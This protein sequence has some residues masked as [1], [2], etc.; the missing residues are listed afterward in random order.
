MRPLARNRNAARAG[1]GH[2]ALARWICDIAYILASMSRRAYRVLP[3]DTTTF[4]ARLFG[5]H[6]AVAS[7][8][9]LSALAGADMLKAGGN[10]IDAAVAASFVEGLVN[11]Q[12]HTIGG[13]CPLLLRLAG[14][15]ER[16]YAIN[17]NGAA[18]APDWTEG[19]LSAAELHPDGRLEAG[20]DPRGSK[21]EVFPS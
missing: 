10:A 15:G 12:M 1:T 5:T 11:P 6:G 4:H 17:G 18:P 16:V 8:S 13:E 9:N 3:T 21:A 7:N 20:C 19:F 2:S 14:G